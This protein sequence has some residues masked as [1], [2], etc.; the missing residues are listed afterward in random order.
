VLA[1]KTLPKVGMAVITDVGDKDDIH[2]TRKEPVGARLALAARGIAYGEK[3]V[4]S[5]PLYKNSKIEGDKVTVGFDSVGSGLESR[6]G[7]LQGFAMAGAD[8]HFVW[9]KA[10]I[11]GDKVVVRSPEVPHPVA[12][13]YGWAD[14]P[15]VNLWNKDGLPASP[16]RTDDFPMV[17]GPKK[18][19]GMN[20]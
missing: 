7:E 20:R 2:P 12:V 19:L 13:R 8:R 15:V 18:Q 10:E 5:G 1:T 17:T 4:F 6:G 11:Q 9:A 16:F 3:I 14:Y